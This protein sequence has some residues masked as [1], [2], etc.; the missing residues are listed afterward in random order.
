MTGSTGEAIG[1]AAVTAM[2]VLSACRAGPR[3]QAA[4]IL[5]GAVAGWRADGPV[6][7][8]NTETIFNYIDGHAEVYL[9]YGM[10]GCTSRRYIGPDGEPDLIADVFEMASPEDAFGV[11]THD[12]S[13]EPVGVGR[14][15]RYRW[16]WLSFWQGPFFVSVTAEADTERARAAVLALGEAVAATLPE[17]GTRP[18]IVGALPEAD[19]DL[20]SVRYLHHPT[21][22]NAHVWLGLDNPF[23]LDAD[24]PAT[25]G[26]YATDG[27]EAFVLIVDYP[28]AARARTAVASSMPAAAGDGEAVDTQ[29]G[30]VAWTLADS[31]RVA[32]V[33]QGSSGEVAT[34]LI[35]RFTT[36]GRP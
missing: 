21:V 5:P 20:E 11:F 12:R 27:G 7:R 2:L 32:F 19:L 34:Q 1:I 6:Q 4:S 16:G 23:G 10:R 14:D 36:G 33:L 22:L 3:D 28:D 26:R 25:L 18:A 24:T 15:A 29:A 35:T 8:W 31:P 30:W 13:G 9:A 17:A